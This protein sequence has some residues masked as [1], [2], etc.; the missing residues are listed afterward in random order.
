M[1][2]ETQMDVGFLEKVG[3]TLTSFSEGFVNFL[4]RLLGSS[5]ENYI[6]KLGYVRSR[7]RQSYTV[8]PG[9]LLARVNELEPQMQA[10]SD[11]DLKALTPKFRERLKAG[12]TLD[13]LL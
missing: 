9:S 7:D 5:N 12:E 6:R 4:T 8:T 13:D 2:T 10:M 11:A 1:A 3:D